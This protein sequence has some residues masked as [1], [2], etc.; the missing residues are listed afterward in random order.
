MGLSARVTS[1]DALKTFRGAVAEFRSEAGAALIEAE[2]E[3]QRTLLWLR[4]DQLAHWQR[5]VRLRAELL[6]RAKTDLYRKQVAQEAQVRAGVDQKKAVELAK[7]RLEE[8]EEKIVAVKRWITV[9]D[10]EVVLYKGEIQTLAGMIDGPL[11]QGEGRLEGMVKSLEAYAAIAAPISGER[12]A[13]ADAP[14]ESPTSTPAPDQAPPGGQQSPETNVSP[15][16]G[17][18]APWP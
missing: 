6:T 4:H 18:T 7:R 9:L 16:E 11:Q 2:S 15:E 10:R 17:G 12:G 1:I 3:I 5:Q 13:G 14:T 8:A